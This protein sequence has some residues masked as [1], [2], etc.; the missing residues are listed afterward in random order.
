MIM[1]TSSCAEMSSFDPFD[2]ALCSTSFTN[3]SVTDSLKQ[4]ISLYDNSQ[5]LLEVPFGVKKTILP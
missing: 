5:I 2:Q 4:A 1:L 3:V